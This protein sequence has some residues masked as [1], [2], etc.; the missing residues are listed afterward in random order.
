[1]LSIISCLFWHEVTMFWRFVGFGCVFDP[2][3][4]LVVTSLGGLQRFLRSSH[5][6]FRVCPK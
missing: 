1:M 4:H 5:W 2:T 3:V 6:C